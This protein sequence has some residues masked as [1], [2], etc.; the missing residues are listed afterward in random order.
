MDAHLEQKLRVVG[1]EVARLRLQCDE[2]A[3]SS[4]TQTDLQQSQAVGA[5]H[6]ARER[7]EKRP[8]RRGKEDAERAEGNLQLEGAG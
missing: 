4:G 7:T 3:E 5:T 1:L 8:E 2:T 6:R